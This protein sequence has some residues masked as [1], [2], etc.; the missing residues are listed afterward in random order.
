MIMQNPHVIGNKKIPTQDWRFK[1]HY[2]K[3]TVNVNTEE[4]KGNRKQ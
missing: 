1:I 2:T 4:E 3:A